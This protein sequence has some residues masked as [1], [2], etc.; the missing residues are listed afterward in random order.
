MLPIVSDS[1]R[2]GRYDPSLGAAVELEE[3]E[4]EDMPSFVVARVWIG[5]GLM[6]ER[7]RLRKG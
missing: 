4:E 1:V 5:G 6:G 2:G 7:K 3:E